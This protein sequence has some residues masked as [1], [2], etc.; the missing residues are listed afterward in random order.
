LLSFEEGEEPEEAPKPKMRSSHIVEEEPAKSATGE[1]TT[2][3]EKAGDKRKRTDDDQVLEL[4][5]QVI[6]MYRLLQLL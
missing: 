4:S 2:Q 3:E 6:V 5:F 1:K